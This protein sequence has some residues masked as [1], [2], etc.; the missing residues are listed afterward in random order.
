MKQLFFS[1]LKM[2][3]NWSFFKLIVFFFSFGFCSLLLYATFFITD[4]IALA[5]ISSNIKRYT[6]TLL[7]AFPMF[8]GYFILLLA[9]K[10]FLDFLK[11]KQG[12]RLRLRMISSFLFITLMHLAFSIFALKI[13]LQ[14]AFNFSVDERL[15]NELDKSI[16]SLQKEMRLYQNTDI[17]SLIKISK[18]KSFKNHAFE[19][20]MFVNEKNEKFIVNKK[21][22]ET[23]KPFSRPL[24]VVVNA[25]NKN[26]S[27]YENGK[28]YSILYAKN[29]INREK[30]YW[31]GVRFLDKNSESNH[32]ASLKLLQG[33]KRIKLFRGF[34]ENTF[35][36][37]YLYCYIILFAIGIAI[38]YTNSRRT[39]TPISLLTNA[40]KQISKGNYT[41]QIPTKG[42][43]EIKDLINSF[44]E[45]TDQLKKNRGKIKKISHIEAWQ[46][47]AMKLTHE[48][49][50]PLTPLRLASD[51]IQ[52][53][54][55]K[56]DFDLFVTLNDSFN[57]INDE[58]KVIEELVHNFSRFAQKI[59]V[60]P[61]FINTDILLERI[62]SLLAHYPK[63]EH[64]FDLQAP[65]CNLFA[66]K[67]KLYQELSNILRNALYSIEQIAP[68]PRKIKISTYKKIIHQK[69]HWSFSLSDKGNGIE[70][71]NKEK[72]FT[73]Y[74]STKKEGMGLGL[75]I[76]EQI[77]TTQKGN[78]SF[79][80]SKDSTTF[81]ISLPIAK[82]QS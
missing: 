36:F 79:E 44:T 53:V 26:F 14:N 37:I 18:N 15:A 21:T 69:P 19:I 5:E 42:V 40:A 66:D 60:K 59:E 54:L 8:L 76:C 25:Q 7:L 45:M 23:Y 48:I 31:V 6:I 17:K 43:D 65:V 82:T 33:I 35:F 16:S 67:T 56:K 9:F 49:K 11:K 28:I 39:F 51:Q 50:N 47:V 20:V 77:L 78:I 74:F 2:F 73:P 38:F 72:I 52:S 12:S 34:L 62:K 58:I 75:Y 13:F 1:P 61:K 27:T 46:E 68:R 10:I 70:E 81:T 55:I 30:G 32:N 41:I 3:K 22:E 24:N 4:L 63:V 57:L 71:K 80:S 29:P 64:T